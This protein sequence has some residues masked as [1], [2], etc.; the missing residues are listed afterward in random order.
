M[1][2]LLRLIRL[3]YNQLR[4]M[5]WSTGPKLFDRAIVPTYDINV[6][7][8]AFKEVLPE[9]INAIVTSHKLTELP[10]VQNWMKKVS[11]TY[12]F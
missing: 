7:K 12:F 11:E 5:H 2:T 1:A 10:E 9:V 6:E 3:I 4:Q 8:K